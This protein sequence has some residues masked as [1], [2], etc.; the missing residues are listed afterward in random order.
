[1]AT[2]RFIVRTDA[3]GEFRFNLEASN[4][5]VILSSEGYTTKANCLNGI[6][7]VR[8][9]AEEDRSYERNIS[10]TGGYHFNLKAANGQ[11]IGT[12]QHYETSVGMEN[13]IHS[14]MTHAP[15]AVTLEG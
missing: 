11:I 12:S 14:V 10:R 6:A 2:G 7:S 5:Q 13:G 3:R 9:H 15:D 8:K 4:G 1:M